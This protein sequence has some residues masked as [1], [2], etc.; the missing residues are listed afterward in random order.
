MTRVFT[1]F[2]ILLGA[3][4]RIHAL[5][6]D[7]RFHSDEALFST[8]ARAA[9]LNGDWW[10]S[11]ALDKPPLVLYLN[12]LSQV[13]VGDNEFAS[14]L[15]GV[16]ASVL[17]LP[18]MYAL[19]KSLYDNPTVVVYGDLPRQLPIIALLLTALS[20]FALAFSA[21]ALTDGPMLLFMTLAL[22][23]LARNRWG[24]SG[25]WLGLGFASKF[26]ALFYLPL[27]VALGWAMGA[28]S[29]KRYTRLLLAFAL[30]VVL[31]VF[32]DAAR[33]GMGVFAL[34]AANNNPARLIRADE[35]IPR[36]Q[37][38][39]HHGQFLLGPGWFTAVLIVTALVVI[40]WRIARQPRRRHTMIDVMLLNFSLG[41]GLLHWLIAFNTFDRYLLLVLPPVIL[42]VARGIEAFNRQAVAAR[43]VWLLPAALSLVLL[44]PAIATVEGRREIN[45]TYR[46]YTGIDDLAAFLNQ[47][48]V[49][50]V[51][52]DRW[53]GWELGYYL[54][55]WHDKRLTYY[56]TPRA[57]VADALAL[58]EIGPRYFPVPRTHSAGPWLEALISAGFEVKVAY[59]N[60][61]FLAY[62]LI[63]PWSGASGVESGEGP[64][65]TLVCRPALLSP[66][67]PDSARASLSGNR[68]TSPDRPASLSAHG[69]R[70]HAY[71]PEP[72]RQFV[73]VASRSAGRFPS[74]VP[75][76]S[77]VSP[78]RGTPGL[79]PAHSGL[80]A[81]AR[82]QSRSP[83]VG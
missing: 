38:W 49:A 18:V 73:D 79:A 62:R 6:R 32:W 48:P 17:L 36:L 57:L 10:L 77:P 56:P 78:G 47:Q 82:S 12:A 58:C 76:H 24:W 59:E 9:A 81:P 30:I 41:Y 44:S 42:L 74:A 35:I 40:G 45:I 27:L 68:A 5:V 75:G 83:G 43:S 2:I 51:I 64:C 46:Q 33:P 34:A 23:M 65:A 80:P 69:Y 67:L 26:Q 39:L 3:G 1:L 53:L 70:A 4:L 21:T 37:T 25:L 61:R 14:R 72:T 28:F 54:G 50:T 19:A 22:W 31:L 13:V 63:P 20:P 8:F 29:L 71:D 52:Y 55:Q 11:G 60:E 7:T 66:S 15:P 16:L